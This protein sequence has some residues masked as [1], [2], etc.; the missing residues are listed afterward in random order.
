MSS[1][2]DPARGGARS[3]LTQA[4]DA[5]AQEVYTAAPRQGV[6]VEVTAVTGGVDGRLGAHA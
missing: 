6:V 5:V 1:L 2:H 4:N 3:S